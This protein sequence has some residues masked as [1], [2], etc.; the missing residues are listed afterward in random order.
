MTAESFGNHCKASDILR[1]LAQR[2]AGERVSLRYIVD[3]LGERAFGVLLLIFALPNAVGLGTIPGVSTLFGVPQIFVAT[4]MLLGRQELWL[5]HW[6]L[7]RSIARA[8]FQKMVDRSMPHILKIERFL[9]PRLLL[10][11]EKLAEQILGLV[12]LGLAVIVSLPIPFGNQP[13]A[14]AMAIIAFGL[15]ARD[16]LYILIGLA[17]AVAA[18]AI[19]GAVVL[20]GVAA[21]W[22]AIQH[23]FGG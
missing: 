6:L 9:R 17:V 11:S 12:F 15:I 23:F 10:L 18:V 21:I 3:G 5:P 20:G 4:Q 19:A 7:D 2:A 14:V 8:D 13:P 1:D 16:G 22:L